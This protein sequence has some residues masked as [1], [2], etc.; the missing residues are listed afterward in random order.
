MELSDQDQASNSVVWKVPLPPSYQDA[1][2][3]MVILAAL[4]KSVKKLSE[5]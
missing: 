2:H 3:F 1:N 4:E 5:V